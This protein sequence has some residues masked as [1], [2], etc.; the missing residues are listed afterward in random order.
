MFTF[1]NIEVSIILLIVFLIGWVVVSHIKMAILERVALQILLER[2]SI[3]MRVEEELGQFYA[4]RL[5]TGAFVV[6][7]SSIEVLIENL[8]NSYPGCFGII[9]DRNIKIP[10]KNLQ[11]FIKQGTQA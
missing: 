7:G 2:T 3:P 10:I 1:Q 9:P 5:D 6:Q 8:R 4:Y 11:D